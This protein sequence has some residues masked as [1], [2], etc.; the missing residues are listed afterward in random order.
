M[1]NVLSFLGVV[2]GTALAYAILSTLIAVVF[3]LSYKEVAQ[4]P[5]TLFFG[6]CIAL[7]GGFLLGQAIDESNF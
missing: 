2:F 3:C 5:A 6:G 7:A 4:C 1:K